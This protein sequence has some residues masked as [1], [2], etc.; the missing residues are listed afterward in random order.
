M[1]SVVGMV[2]F[3]LP[4]LLFSHQVPSQ[5]IILPANP[6]TRA[7]AASAIAPPIPQQR[8]GDVEP[9][10]PAALAMAFDIEFQID[11]KPNEISALF[12]E[13]HL[14]HLFLEHR[15]A[16]EAAFSD[17]KRMNCNKDSPKLRIAINTVSSYPA[18]DL[19]TSIADQPQVASK[20]QA[21]TK[22]RSID[23]AGVKVLPFHAGR[24]PQPAS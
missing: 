15:N 2:F 4:L 1:R 12:A 17:V 11:S 8:A 16:I 7:E 19:H 3:S 18:L 13:R 20:D 6:A 23:F 22:L 14:L 9:T 24:Q 10:S 5:L 21:G